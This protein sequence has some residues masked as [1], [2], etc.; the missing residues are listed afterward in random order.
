VVVTDTL[1]LAP[2]QHHDKI[3]VLSI[4]PLIAEVIERIYKG[5]TI[6]DKLV[7]T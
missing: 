4:A 7:L 6:S 5:E 3:V 2:N 1:P